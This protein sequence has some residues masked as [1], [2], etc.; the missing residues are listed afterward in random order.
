MRGSGL[1]T[2]AA[3]AALA[4]CAPSM[5]VTRAERVCTDQIAASLAPPEAGIVGSVGIGVGN[6]G[7]ISD[8]DLGLV[9]TRPI[10]PRDPDAAYARCVRRN[11]GQGP[12]RPL[13]L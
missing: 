1:I 5:S 6:D 2:A 8:V 3:L 10:P 12:T 9:V 7:P 4:G 13:A 11:S